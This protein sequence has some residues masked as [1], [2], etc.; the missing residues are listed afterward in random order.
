MSN[1]PR[2]AELSY[3]ILKNIADMG[4]VTKRDID[5]NEEIKFLDCYL[6]FLIHN[7]FISERR[8]PR[9]LYYTLTEKGSELYKVLRRDQIFKAVIKIGKR[10][11]GRSK[12]F[13][14][15]ASTRILRKTQQLNYIKTY[16]S[17][18][19]LFIKKGLCLHIIQRVSHLGHYNILKNLL[20]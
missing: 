18:R 10:E 19:D 9:D 6:N 5:E 14:S 15:L 7:R 12:R 11:N 16:F 4:E 3:K 2:P 20:R 13:F 1:K 8:G 17:I